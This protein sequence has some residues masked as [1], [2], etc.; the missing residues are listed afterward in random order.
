LSNK[1]FFPQGNC[2]QHITETPPPYPFWLKKT[3]IN[4]IGRINIISCYPKSFHVYSKKHLQFHSL[5][6]CKGQKAYMKK[7]N[8]SKQSRENVPIISHEIE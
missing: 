8:I 3:T 7:K 4:D 1:V 5:D 2:P 6:F